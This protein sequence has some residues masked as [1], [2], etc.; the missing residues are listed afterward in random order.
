M[1]ELDVISLG[2][3]EMPLPMGIQAESGDLFPGLT[4]HDL[5]HIEED[6]N[7]VQARGAAENTDFLAV[8]DVD[9]NKLEE[10]GWG[11]IFPSGIDP[12]VRAAL[13]P[14][15]EHRR[16]QVGEPKLFKIFEGQSGYQHVD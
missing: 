13:E 15:I 14:L 4:A 16:Q 6:P 5:Q 8:A 11:V 9:S 2:P 7:A 12:A 10:A 1:S 3:D